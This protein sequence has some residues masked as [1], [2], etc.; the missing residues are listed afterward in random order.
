MDR[1]QKSAARLDK[2]LND[3]EAIK[4]LTG[5]VKM[6]P[7]SGQWI[8]AREARLTVA[9]TS[10]VSFGEAERAL[11]RRALRW[12]RV[13]PHTFSRS[14]K[15]IEGIDPVDF[16]GDELAPD[17]SHF[18]DEPSRQAWEEALQLFDVLA[19]HDAFDLSGAVELCCWATGDFKVA[20]PMD[21]STVTFEIVG[22]EF[23]KQAVL[24]SI[25]VHE[26]EAQAKPRAP[27]VGG[28]PASKH[29]DI[30]AAATIRLS[31]LPP[32]QLARY[33][34]ASLGTELADAYKQL[35]EAPPAE[36]NCETY[37]AG[38]LRVLRANQA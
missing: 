20:V 32:A 31:Q 11:C 26:L 35:G 27:L 5:P 8:S 19:N 25:G 3:P 28:R 34:V 24:E 37:A 6:P 14:E 2:I 9:R 38:I 22:L 36:K 4:S 7:P 17:L 12:I 18:K 21:F 29:G 13:Q 33:T 1:H 15:P 10:E 16:F 23:D 30:I